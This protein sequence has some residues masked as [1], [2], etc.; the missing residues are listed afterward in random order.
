[1]VKYIMNNTTHSATGYA[2]CT[3]IF[4]TESVEDLQ[5]M[6]KQGLEME[7]LEPDKWLRALDSNYRTLKEASIL[8]Q[9]NMAI[10]RHEM[11]IKDQGR[12]GRPV[13]S[14]IVRVKSGATATTPN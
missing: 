1:M 9:D 2:P 13:G 4:G 8:F 7:M 11:S 10:E 14:G 3:L 12:K 5:I 6:S